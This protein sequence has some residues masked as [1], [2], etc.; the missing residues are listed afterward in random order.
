MMMSKSVLVLILLAAV[1]AIPLFGEDGIFTF[2]MGGG[3]ST[4]LNPTGQYAGTS[5][6][7]ETGAGYKINKRN[8]IIGEFMWSGLPPN[9]FV[10]QPASAPF[11]T[12]NVYGLTANY[13]YEFDR[14]HGSR[15]GLYAIGGGGWYYRHASIDKSYVVPPNTA[16]QPFYTWWGYACNPSG[17]VYTQ[18]VASKGTSV[19]GLNGGFGFSIGIADSPWKFYSEARYH[20]A[21]N[22][23][24]PTAV[25]PVTF[26]F[27]LN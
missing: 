25:V 27:R 3:I 23:A 16:C 14:I 4:P 21:F 19:G 24:I 9:I 2:N 22:P 10:L 20:Y 12:V 11:G 26:G 5:G 6:N 8:S 18:T 7:F 17:L 15:F 1:P 13:R